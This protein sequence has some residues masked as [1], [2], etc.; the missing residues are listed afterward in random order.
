MMSPQSPTIFHDLP[1]LSGVD[2]WHRR[3]G[4][5]RRDTLQRWAVPVSPCISPHRHVSPRIL[6]LTTSTIS[7]GELVEA[8]GYFGATLSG[9]AL[10]LLRCVLFYLGATRLH[11]VCVSCLNG[12][13]LDGQWL[14]TDCST[15]PWTTGCMQ[16]RC[17]TRCS[18]ARAVPLPLS[19]SPPCARWISRDLQRC[20]PRIS[21]KLSDRVH[22]ASPRLSL[23]AS[24]PRHLVA[25]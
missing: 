2:E 23:P 18:S 6:H 19:S 8:V 7:A 4:R 9:T 21:N 24:P 3:V 20:P 15:M 1:S 22:P 10:L 25:E 13:W 16:A 12:R 11:L 17:Y 14:T 5:A